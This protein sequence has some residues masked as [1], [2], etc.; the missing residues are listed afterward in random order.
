MQRDTRVI[1]SDSEAIQNKASFMDCFV[2]RNDALYVAF[3][4]ASNSEAIRITY[5]ML[6][7]FVPRNDGAT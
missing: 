7:C 3:V 1:A 2:P 4:M 5:N 6:D